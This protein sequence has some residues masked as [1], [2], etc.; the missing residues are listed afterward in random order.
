MKD[1]LGLSSTFVRSVTKSIV[2]ISAIGMAV[3]ANIDAASANPITYTQSAIASGSLGS[4]SFSSA[5]VTITFLA[6]TSGV[7]CVGANDC[8][9]HGTMSVSIAG[10]GT[11]TFTDSGVLA[12][13]SSTGVL[14]QP[15][16]TVGVADPVVAGMPA[17]ILDTGSSAFA[18][19]SLMTS[20]GPITG[21]AFINSGFAFPTSD[22]NFTLD[23]INSNQSTF[24]ASVVPGPIVG[25]GLPGLILAGGGLLAWWRRRRQSA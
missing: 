14:N 7:S 19:Y 2:F 17:I 25:A 3:A 20:I 24:S 6:D 4:N 5:L 9:N 15:T 1:H 18:G 10:I 16:P 12:F 23:F 11:A 13:I 22:G 21:A 8:T